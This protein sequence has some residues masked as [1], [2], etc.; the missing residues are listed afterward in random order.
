[1]KTYQFTIRKEDG[2]QKVIKIKDTDI[3]PAIENFKVTA[4]G[5]YGLSIFEY[6]IIKIEV[7]D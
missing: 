1:M 4:F 5:K 6:E 3:I 7:I 2:N